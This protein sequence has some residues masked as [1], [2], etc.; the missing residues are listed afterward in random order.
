M[1][2]NGVHVG[3]K[4]LT[5]PHFFNTPSRRVAEGRSVFF[6]WENTP[7]LPD[8]IGGPPLSK[9]G[10]QMLFRSRLAKTQIQF[11]MHCHF[12]NSLKPPSLIR[13]G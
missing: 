3:V 4:T 7:R 9:E 10:I 12:V 8:C 2:A 5:Y 11:S 6:L 1:D 13:L